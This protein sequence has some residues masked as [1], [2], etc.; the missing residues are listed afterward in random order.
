MDQ[1]SQLNIENFRAY[2]KIKL[3]YL[4]FPHPVQFERSRKADWLYGLEGKFS[5]KWYQFWHID[6]S[7]IDT[8]ETIEQGIG[9][10]TPGKVRV[11]FQAEVANIS[12]SKT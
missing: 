4:V 6:G 10:W 12:S 1:C 11:V 7:G 5:L 9:V 2:V 8:G 3:S